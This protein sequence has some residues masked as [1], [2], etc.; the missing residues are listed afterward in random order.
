[1]KRYWIIPIALI[2]LLCSII[3]IACQEDPADE[4][5]SEDLYF[6]NAY[7]IDGTPWAF[8]GT[9]IGLTDTP[10]A[11]AGHA[12]EGVRVNA[13]TN[14]LEFAAAGSG[15]VSAAANL[16]DNAIIR[17]DG[18]A[19]GIQDS[20]IDI[21]DGG[22]LD[23]NTGAITDV[24]TVD[25][26]DVS[27]DGA[28]L[29]GIEAGA[30][31]TDAANVAAAGA[32]MAST[33]DT[34]VDG[35]VDTAHGGTEWDSSAQT[36]FPYVTAGNWAAIAKGI[37]NGNVMTVDQADAADDEFAR[38]TANGLESL[39]KA[40]LLAAINVADGADVTGS[41]APQAHKDSHDPNDGG[42]PLDTAAPSELASV[43]ASGVG[44]SHSLARADHQHQI[45][46]SIADNHLVTVDGS[47]SAN[48]NVLWTTSGLDGYAL[49][50]STFP[51][52][53]TDGMRF[54]HE[55]TGRKILYVYDED[56]TVWIPVESIGDMTL[57]VNV[58]GATAADT[59]SNGTTSANG[60]L[61][62]QYAIDVIPPLFS[63]DVNIY[64]DYGEAA[65]NSYA[66]S[67]VVRG[68][69]PTKNVSI[70]IYGNLLIASGPNAQDSSVQG[71]GAVQ[72]SI[73][74]AGA[75][76]AYD[77]MIL[78]SSNNA[79]YRII[80]SDDANTATIVGCWSAAPTGNYTVYD[81]GTSITSLTNAC[82][83][84]TTVVIY[85]IKFTSGISGSVG[86][87]TYVYR[88]WANAM[89]VIGS[90]AFMSFNQSYLYCASFFAIFALQ[91]YIDCYMSKVWCDSIYVIYLT[92][93]STLRLDGSIVDA[94]D[95]GND[96]LYV[97]TG[98]I[99]QCF[100]YGVANN[101]I[102][103]CNNGVYASTGGNVV[104]T[105]YNT[106]TNNNADETAGANG[107]ID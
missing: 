55:I 103:N 79:E 63:G 32:M 37:A 42:D 41:N 107:Y 14:A 7:H 69:T 86:S 61:T 33:Y 2:L 10:G 93:N 27:V 51:T 52:N 60:F 75:F 58:D 84:G 87:T 64:I 8:G 97:T 76:G 38:F 15:D 44:T 18:G 106:Y 6:D 73:T 59:L 43:Q 71:G 54:V 96:G 98:S 4:F 53:A 91:S 68:K 70:Y 100:I 90:T 16:D 49:V 46:H 50:G 28:K 80:D 83:K 30:D 39:S 3:P 99:A 17:G 29:D 9:F 1:L 13:A 26:R 77:N 48:E 36:G 35:L 57:Y 105:A 31:V 102:R 45:Q 101:Q 78:Y 40:E 25:G 92:M 62:I 56:N 20:A 24:G 82:N 74:D 66:E 81:W 11:Y 104:S 95:K 34:D 67:V 23:M 89:N 47:P 12:L 5:A 65:A 19:K 94:S 21:T 72:G 22:D 88:G 85:D